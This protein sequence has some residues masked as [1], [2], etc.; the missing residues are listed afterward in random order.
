YENFGMIFPNDVSAVRPGGDGFQTVAAF[1]VDPEL[2][3][4]ARRSIPRLPSIRKGGH[5]VS[6]SVGGTGVT[7][8]VFLDNAAYRK[9]VFR[10]WQ[11]RCVDM[12][13]TA[14]AHVAYANRKPILIVRAL[15]DLAGGQQG[16]NPIDE[17]E[18]RVSEIAA[19]VLRG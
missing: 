12:E 15:S 13:S 7:G 10:V 3:A 19:R 18:A 17:N 9:W 8:P 14:L 2:L 1:P 5:N 4:A 11:A 6:V 16:K